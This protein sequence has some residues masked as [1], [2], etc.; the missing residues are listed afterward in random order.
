MN[1]KF[2][3]SATIPG[4]FLVPAQK[5]GLIIEKNQITISPLPPMEVPVPTDFF[6]TLNELI[7]GC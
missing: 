1:Q 3:I 7:P 6:N 5:F 4:V 2:E